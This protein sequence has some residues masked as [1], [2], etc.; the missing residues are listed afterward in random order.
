MVVYEEITWKVWYGGKFFFV[1][2]QNNSMKFFFLL[3][4]IILPSQLKN[5]LKL[6]MDIHMHMH[7]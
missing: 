4:Y 6:K 3:T 2:T 5:K 1:Y 7:A